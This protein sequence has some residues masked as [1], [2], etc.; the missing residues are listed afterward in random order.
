MLKEKQYRGY[1]LFSVIGWAFVFCCVAERD[2]A[3]KGNIIWN[4]AFGIKLALVCLLGGTL[5]GC[6]VYALLLY[7]ERLS[8]KHASGYR[9]R[10]KMKRFSGNKMFLV[11]WA[12]I[13]LCWMPAYLAYYPA[14]CSY[15][16]PI[17]LGQIVDHAYNDHHPIIHTLL[18]SAF[19]Q[20]GKRL[21]DV[22]SG[23]ALYALMQMLLLAAVFAAGS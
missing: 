16:M 20:I 7:L 23:I 8:V 22:N 1:F 4:S 21:G 11:S 13:T 10:E 6:G 14:I 18:I 12:I 3:E 15:D 5:I 19:L 2:L 17:Q 9:P